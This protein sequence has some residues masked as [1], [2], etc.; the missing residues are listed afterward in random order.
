MKN[1][2][3]TAVVLLIVAFFANFFGVV[4]IPW[5]DLPFGLDKQ[6]GGSAHEAAQQAD[7]AVER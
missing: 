4:S 7:Q 2:I 5:L 3:I 6:Y 1:V